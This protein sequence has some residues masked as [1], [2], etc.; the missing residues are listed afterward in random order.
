MKPLLRESFHINKIGY[1][2]CSLHSLRRDAG[3]PSSPGE[4]CD[5]ISFMAFM[6]SFTSNEI[7]F[8]LNRIHFASFLHL[9]DLL[10]EERYQD[11]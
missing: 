2:R 10:V 3:N 4:E 8:K 6:M 1:A 7:S 11:Y 5:I 9:I